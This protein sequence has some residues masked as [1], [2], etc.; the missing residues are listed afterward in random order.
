[1]KRLICSCVRMSIIIIIVALASLSLPI[2]NQVHAQSDIQP[3]SVYW[4]DWS[5]DGTRI[6]I[7]TP[8][9]ISIYDATFRLLAS[10]PQP[11]PTRSRSFTSISPDG[12]HLATEKEIW[13]IETLTPLLQLNSAYSLGD[14]NQSGTIITTVGS[15]MR[16]IIFYDTS[17]GKSVKT[18]ATGNVILT[19]NPVWSPDNTRFAIIEGKNTLALIDA[20]NGQVLARYPHE[21]LLNPVIAWSHNNQY[22][23]YSGF[24]E[25][26]L[27]T[28]GNTIQYSV[29]IADTSNG[30]IVYTFKS[31][32]NFVTQLIWSPDDTQLLAVIGSDQ[33]YIWDT[34]KGQQID[35]YQTVGGLIGVDYSPFSAQ[36]MMGF[37]LY[38]YTP[39]S[40]T[41]ASIVESSITRGFLNG[42]IQ[43][44]VPAPS[45]EKLQAI[46]QACGVQPRVEQSLTAQ[47][48]SDSLQAFSDQV[49]ALTDA[50]IP[51]G[52]K[53]DL[54]AVAEAL[55]A[56][57]Q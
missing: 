57:G 28:T 54:L 44:A 30:Q 46:T 29:Y 7:A 52:C 32:S 45:A 1:M 36:I 43:M 38:W 40:G 9:E 50:Q 55:M 25:P 23:A 42:A 17:T 12:L 22:L 4:F 11:D 19:F 33:V 37:N 48:S 41:N 2:E 24:A 3:T 49:T 31:L 39:P 47:I 53:A 5:Q 56:Q 15:D 10:R 18:I 27:G 14:W 6:A 13:D 34:Q 16:S 20:S 35:S 26:K 8:D 51:P 21:E